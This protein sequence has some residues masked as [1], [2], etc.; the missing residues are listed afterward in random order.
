[1]SPEKPLSAWAQLVKARAERTAARRARQALEAER[2]YARDEKRRLARIKKSKLDE[3]RMI[4]GDR[5]VYLDERVE[6]R[7]YNPQELYLRERELYILA[8]RR[9][10]YLREVARQS[11]VMVALDDPESLEDAQ[12]TMDLAL[13]AESEAESQR[14]IMRR[15]KRLWLAAPNTPAPTTPTQGG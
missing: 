1:M 7:Q 14:G 11:Q 15:R 3:A 5:R 2:I 9:A 13:Q 4:R 8:Q 6:L 10:A 12:R